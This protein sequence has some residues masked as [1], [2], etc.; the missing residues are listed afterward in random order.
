MKTNFHEAETCVIRNFEARAMRQRAKKFAHK[1]DRRKGDAK[2]SWK[3]EE[4]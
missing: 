4:F 1:N 3:R 2:K